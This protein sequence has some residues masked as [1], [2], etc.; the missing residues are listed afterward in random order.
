[1]PFAMAKGGKLYYEVTGRGDPIVFVHEFGGDHRSW[2]TQVRHFSRRYRCVTYNARGY[3]PSDVPRRL[4]DYAQAEQAEDVGRVMRHVGIKRAHVVGLSMGAFA[5]LHFGLRHPSM[6]SS[7]TIAGCGSGA[8]KN[9]RRQFQRDALAAADALLKN[10]MAK[11]AAAIAAGPTRIQLRNK[12]PRGW[13]EFSRHLADHSAKGSAMTLRGYQARRPSLYDMAAALRRLKVPTLL[14]VGDEDDPCLE[15]T[16]YLKRCIA[17]AGLWIA[18]NTG[19]A[20][21]LEEPEAFN[22]MLENVRA[23]V[24]QCRWPRRDP[25]SIGGSSLLGTARKK[26]R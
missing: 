9:A 25:R 22:L 20:I 18:P 10:G 16:L 1:M 6:A 21:N 14:M 4:G 23:R 15:A 12:D 3:P 5:A 13:A 7:L 17:T 19:H 11:H 8:P 24:E 2:E 26:R